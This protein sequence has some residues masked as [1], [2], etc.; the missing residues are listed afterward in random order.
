[1]PKSIF[2]YLLSGLFLS[3]TPKSI[4][5]DTQEEDDQEDDNEEDNEED[6]QEEDDQEEDD[7]EED[8]EEDDQ[9][10][11]DQEEDDQEEEDNEGECADA[12]SASHISICLVAAG[13]VPEVLSLERPIEGTV[14][15]VGTGA[16]PEGCVDLHH[17]LGSYTATF[18]PA[19]AQW[20]RIE[21]AEGA[22]WTL[23]VLVPVPLPVAAGDVLDIDY[24]MERF[25]PFNG[26]YGSYSLYI[27]DQDGGS[28][29]WAT[30]TGL[31][32]FDGGLHVEFGS[33]DFT[34]IDDCSTRDYRELSF[35]LGTDSADVPFGEQLVLGDHIAVN[36]G[37]IEKS[38]LICSETEGSRAS[39][40]V[41]R[42]E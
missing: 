5:K 42:Q 1:M 20:L 17:S 18:D 27:Q 2:F 14:A 21:D 23:A 8:N 26:E 11:D 32:D 10:E 39:M 36:A 38:D 28:L 13:A 22:L 16:P 25:L 30:N 35:Q 3:C 40:A 9:E 29:L 33:S 4:E 37:A 6:D 19:D 24:Q 15:E 41:V 31:G 7:Q 34:C 12:P